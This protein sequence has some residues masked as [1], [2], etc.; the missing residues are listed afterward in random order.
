MQMETYCIKTM[1][2]TSHSY[3]RPQ[4]YLHKI[5]ILI[6]CVSHGVLLITSVGGPLVAWIALG[7]QVTE[8]RLINVDPTPIGLD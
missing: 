5:K 8:G 7:I 3:S 4:Y 6:L 1:L 2:K